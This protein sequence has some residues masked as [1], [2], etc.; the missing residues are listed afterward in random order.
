MLASGTWLVDSQ[1]APSQPH[2]ASP[3]ALRCHPR[4]SSAMPPSSCPG[5][6]SSWTAP[7]CEFG[8]SLPIPEAS[9]SR[10]RLAV[11]FSKSAAGPSASQQGFAQSKSFFLMGPCLTV[12]PLTERALGVQP[13]HC[14]DLEIRSLQALCF[15]TLRSSLRSIS[16]SYHLFDWVGHAGS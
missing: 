12:F 3:Y 1:P 16:S 2:W 7:S 13:T 10:P 4:V 5:P 15:C 6:S 8:E 9:P 11:I 14:L